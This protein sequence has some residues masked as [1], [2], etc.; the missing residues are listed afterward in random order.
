MYVIGVWVYMK[1][2]R[3]KNWV[4][5]LVSWAFVV[6]LL[7]IYCADRF[8]PPPE[9]MTEVAQTGLIATAITILWV[10]WFDRNRGVV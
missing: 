4:G 1:M 3:G 8:S 9:S 6:V 5:R 10:W 2:T 7:G